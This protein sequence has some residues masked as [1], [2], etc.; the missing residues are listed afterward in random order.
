MHVKILRGNNEDHKK[1][2]YNFRGKK[3]FEIIIKFIK[4]K[5]NKPLR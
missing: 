3:F 2:Q 5:E 4:V 1:R